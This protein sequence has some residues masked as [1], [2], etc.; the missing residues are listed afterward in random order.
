MTFRFVLQ[1]VMATIAALVDGGKDAH[2]GLARLCAAPAAA[3]P[4]RGRCP[5]VA[6]SRLCKPGPVMGLE[7]ED[8]RP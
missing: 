2:R 6:R 1:P 7:F 5:R 4:D 3:S 8:Q